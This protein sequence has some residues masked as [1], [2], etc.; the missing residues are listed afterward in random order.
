M[1]SRHR[2]LLNGVEHTVVVDEAGGRTTVAVDDA[3]PLE[4]DATTSGLPGLFSLLIDGQPATAYVSRRGS[5]FEVTVGGRA[6]QVEPATARGRRGPI[7]GL[8][9][10]LGKVTAP[11]AGV[12]VEVHVQVGEAIAVGQPLLV[13]EA[14]KMQN[15]VQAPH[16][17]TVTAVHF[18]KGDR[19]EKG[20]VLVE[21]EPA[22]AEA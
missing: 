3:P 19:A 5:G 14:M 21:Y 22:E 16:A 12:V 4:V 15:E 8:E 7:G 18:A 13:L 9:D 17:G 20:A 2:L 6:F 10:P 11:L 1:A